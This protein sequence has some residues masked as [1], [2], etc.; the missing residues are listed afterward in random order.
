[1][2]DIVKGTGGAASVGGPAGTRAPSAALEAAAAAAGAGR[3]ASNRPGGAAVRGPT[4]AE[5]A[6]GLDGFESPRDD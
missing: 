4:L 1:M 6:A 3:Q 2:T 5:I